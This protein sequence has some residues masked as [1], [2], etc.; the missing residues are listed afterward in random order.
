METM[1]SSRI[2]PAFA[3]GPSLSRNRRWV[4]CEARELAVAIEGDLRDV[5]GAAVAIG[6]D[7]GLPVPPDGDETLG[8]FP[9]PF[10]GVPHRQDQHRGRGVASLAGRGD[11]REAGPVGRE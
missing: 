2:G 8:E 10:S 4:A 3:T 9:A 7:P 5:T 6:A 1:R 11:A